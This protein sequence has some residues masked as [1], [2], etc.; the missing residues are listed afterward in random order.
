MDD[1]HTSPVAMAVPRRPRDRAPWGA[2]RTLQLQLLGT[3]AHSTHTPADDPVPAGDFLDEALQTELN[4]QQDVPATPITN[5][6]HTPI[7]PTHPNQAVSAATPAP[8]SDVGLATVIQQLQ[9]SQR[10][11]LEQQAAAHREEMRKQQVWFQEQLTALQ[12]RTLQPAVAPEPSVTSHPRTVHGGARVSNGLPP[13]AISGSI[14]TGAELSA[15]PG[16]I[17]HA[18]SMHL[19]YPTNSQPYPRM[20]MPPPALQPFQ[21]PRPRDWEFQSPKEFAMQEELLRRNEAAYRDQLQAIEDRELELARS[22]AAE[23]FK[24]EQRRWGGF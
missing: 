22:R 11:M 10:E 8:A 23:H 17:P 4:F 13:A 5:P 16:S 3:P 18:S 21:A 14:N 9:N 6:H 7:T 12:P 2:P 24:Q 20:P 1:E 19:Y 15:Y